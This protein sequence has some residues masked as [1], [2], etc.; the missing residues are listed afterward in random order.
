[1]LVCQEAGAVVV[2]AHGRDL[3][4]LDHAGR[5]TPVA[6]ATPSLLEQLVAARVVD[7]V[8]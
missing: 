3:V 2:D 7:P 6:A 5:R 8:N 4:V 1:M